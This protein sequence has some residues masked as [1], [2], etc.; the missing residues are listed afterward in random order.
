MPS[1]IQ[2]SNGRWTVRWRNPNP[3]PDE[4]KQPSKGGFRTKRDARQWY[5][6]NHGSQKDTN[7]VDHLRAIE[8]Y[9]KAL[10]ESPDESIDLRKLQEFLDRLRT[11][12]DFYNRRSE[13]GTVYIIQGMV[14]PLIKMGY[15]RNGLSN[16]LGQLQAYSPDH[17]RLLRALPGSTSTE[18][19]IH[20]TFRPH[21]R[22]GEWFVPS[23]ALVDFIDST[24]DIDQRLHHLQRKTFD[25]TIE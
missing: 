21:R 22:H 6:H 24:F 8:S 25:L 12:S 14:A 13:E 23:V 19:L 20:R 10:I 15:T 3:K 2:G 9:R 16:R 11:D 17:L 1:Y 4:P 18:S 7:P 5:A